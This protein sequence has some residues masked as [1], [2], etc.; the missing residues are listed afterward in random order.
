MKC[1]DTTF[2][3]DLVQA[4]HRVETLVKAFDESSEILA[5]TVLNLY[6]VLVGA[7]SVKDRRKGAKIEDKVEKATARMEVLPFRDVDA[8]R[9][10]RIAGELR[11]RG[12]QVG[13]DAL[14]AAIAINH[15]CDG[16]V[17]RNVDHFRAIE[18]QTGLEVITY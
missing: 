6:E 13:V 5:T 12:I 17:T 7:Y 3:V 9:G 18:R 8:R 2:L 15:G 1:L 16:V 10:A 14:V 4:P 11:R